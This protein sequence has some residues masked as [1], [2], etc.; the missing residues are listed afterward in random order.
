[1]NS[2]EY[3][4]I[5]E[6]ARK[7]QSLDLLLSARGGW[8]VIPEDMFGDYPNRPNDWRGIYLFGIYKIYKDGDKTIK[9][10]MENAIINI[11]NQEDDDAAYMAVEAW[12]YQ[13]CF[14]VASIAPFCL[15]RKKIL[16]KIRACLRKN[17]NK[18]LNT[19]KWVDTLCEPDGAKNLYEH[20]LSKERIFL[21]KGVDLFAGL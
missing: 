4:M 2:E 12:Y 9:N 3:F 15:E 5:V 16:K 6:K 8:R 21:R 14:E 7:E 1:M 10:E 11:C 13:I 17:K 18:L 20:I 19:D